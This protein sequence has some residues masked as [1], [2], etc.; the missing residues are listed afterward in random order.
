MATDRAVAARAGDVRCVRGRGRVRIS[1]DA[2]VPAAR[3]RG[4]WGC[5]RERRERGE[6]VAPA[7]RARCA[8]QALAAVD[9]PA[10]LLLPVPIVGVVEKIGVAV[11]LLVNPGN[12]LIG[13]QGDLQHYPPVGEFFAIFPNRSAA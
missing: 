1:A 5:R 13:W 2:A 8:R 11:T 9:R 12:S 10:G 3:R 7:T 4:F 6:P